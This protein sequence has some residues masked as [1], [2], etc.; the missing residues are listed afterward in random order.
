MPVNR[1][2][3][4]VLA[5]ALALAACTGDAEKEALRAF[6][7][8]VEDLMEEDGEVAAHLADL[9]EDLLTANSAA[10]D[11]SAYAR[12]QA[13][14][15]YR[16]FRETASRAPA[17]GPRLRGIHGTLVEYADERLGYLESL[18]SFLA[19][20]KSEAMA[21]LRGFQGPW[22]AAQKELVEKTGGRVADRDTADAINARVLFMQSLDAPS[23]GGQAR[24]EDLEAGLRGEL[25]PRL[26]RVA[27]R[28]KDQ[29]TAEGPE[30]AVARWAAAELAF[31]Q[32]LGTTIPQQQ[33]L[34][35]AAGATQ[36][37]WAKAE[38]LKKKFLEDLRGHRDGLR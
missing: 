30:G 7:A 5:A 17:E 34:Q 33:N 14:P 2:R 38:G 20:T 32:E 1:P 10:S 29:R 9:R 36:E 31:F 22:E 11:Q 23:Q 18:E 16:R 27:E 26:S 35:K 24:A 21:R 12:E 6:E 28:T 37:H 8:A 19:A 15:F 25:L 3:A 13:L 4:P